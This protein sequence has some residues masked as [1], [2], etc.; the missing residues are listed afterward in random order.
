MAWTRARLIACG[1]GLAEGVISFGGAIP[2]LVLSILAEGLVPALGLGLFL[3]WPVTSAVR[4]FTN[5]RRRLAYEWAGVSIA[6]PYRPE[7]DQPPRTLVDW[8]RRALAL[9]ADPAH[10]RDLLWLGC[11]PISLVLGMLPAACVVYGLEG[12]LAVPIFT[13]LAGPGYGYTF[14]WAVDFPGEGL[15]AIPQGVLF[16]ALGLAIAPRMQQASAVFARS[17]L[18][19]IR[20]EALSQRVRRLAETRADAVDAQAAE[21]RRLERDLHDGAQAR[22]VAM[23]MSVSMAKDVVATKPELAQQLL[24][25]VLQINDEAMSELRKLIR[26]I[27]PPLLAEQ[28][29][30]VAVRALALAL[31]IP[32]DVDIELPGRLPPAVESAA[33][34]A[35]AEAVANVGK[36]SGAGRAWVMVRHADGRL[37]L[38][39]ADNGR[40]GADP[41]RG[42]GLTGVERRLA[43][44]DGTLDVT[45]PPGGPTVVTMELP[46]TCRL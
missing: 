20:S 1:Q 34:F 27:H 21:L 39:V 33:Y 16:L 3:Q 8:W 26:G 31:P 7:P 42:T 25:E 43:A 15:V 2:L 30:D 38:T 40:G 13:A 5:E 10:W 17:M 18:A 46:C 19:P 23:G 36:H 35:T 44:F 11:A 9:K 14:G 22:M 6:I 45:S 37:L 29:L 12:I 4:A 32:V 24:D 41:R 28:G